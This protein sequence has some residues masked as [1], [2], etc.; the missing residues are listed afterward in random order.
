MRRSGFTLIELVF[1]IV[2]LGILAAVAVPRLA[3]VQ[4][5]ATIATEQAGIAAVKTGIQT[6]KSK[7]I[8]GNTNPV[9]DTVLFNTQ[10]TADT[11]ASYTLAF[12]KSDA[13]GTNPTF[14]N[15]ASGYTSMA[16]SADS[17]A[18]DLTLAAVLEPGSRKQWTTAAQTVT[19]T[20]TTGTKIT[21][22]ASRT[23]TDTSAAINTTKYWEYNPNS[24][25]IIF[26]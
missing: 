23:I 9:S 6:L 21:G 2:I 11:G 12:K 25:V 18:S 15:L 26:K 4:D 24:G 20:V 22:P 5:D 16:T 7:I 19:G 13:T 1:V 8:L 3:G 17:S 14:L 10:V